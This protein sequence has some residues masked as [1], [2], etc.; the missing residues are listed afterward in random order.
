MD[1][2]AFCSILFEILVGRSVVAQISSWNEFVIEL[3]D[4]G[5]RAVIP[6]F[7]PFFMRNLIKTGFAED[8]STQPSFEHVYDVLKENNFDAIEGNDVNEVMRYVSS[9]EASANEGE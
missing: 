8:R 4:N 5:E 7:I 6:T 9:F 2:V 1:L 3:M